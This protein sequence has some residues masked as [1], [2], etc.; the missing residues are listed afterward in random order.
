MYRWWN[1]DSKYNNNNN[2]NNSSQ[3]QNRDLL[4]LDFE[5]LTDVMET[6][7]TNYMTAEFSNTV[8][9]PFQYISLTEMD[10][11]ML[12]QNINSETETNTMNE[13]QIIPVRDG[14][15]RKRRGEV[16]NVSKRYD[17]VAVFTR[18]GDLAIPSSNIVQSKQLLAQEDEFN[19]LL[20][21]LS[22][23]S[24]NTGL[25][26]VASIKLSDYNNNGNTQIQPATP[27]AGGY[28]FVIIVAVIVAGCSMILLAF[29]LHL[30]FRRRNHGSGAP[31]MMVETKL[32][33]RTD[34]DL[35]PTFNEG[36]SPLPPVQVM[37]LHPEHDDNISDYTESVFSLPVQT[38]QQKIKES[39]SHAINGSRNGHHKVS[40]RFNPRYIMS[41]KRSSDGGSDKSRG[42][43]NRD[44]EL[45]MGMSHLA[46]ISN[47]KAE[48]ER[49][50]PND[51]SSAD[52]D[53]PKPGLYPADIID[54]DITSSLS[55]YGNALN[56][57]QGIPNRNQDDGV[58]L[59]SV[60]SYGFSL[61]GGVGDQ[62]TMGNSTK[63]GY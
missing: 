49:N 40:S 42:S 39:L 32:S 9:A 1:K 55:A 50:Q 30:A 4:A 22:R 53:N 48:S 8:Y 5:A 47:T 7:F 29:A 41:S 63:Y 54:D 25:N 57:H 44:D 28:D 14:N 51:I 56:L 36:N 27:T 16:F 17:G 19:D 23:S 21:M 26:N 13:L 6:Y 59:S 11:R 20:D 60:E 35:S 61:E 3:Q 33:P 62:S 18:D 45:L 58:S 24:S 46:S 2:N 38:K 37:E 31:Q 15:L 10:R 34:P 12:L 52:I 43:S